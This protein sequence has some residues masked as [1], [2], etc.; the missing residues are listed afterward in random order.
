MSSIW[1]TGNKGMLGAELSLLLEKT[2]VAFIGSDREVDITD[3]ATLNNFVQGRGIKWIINCAAYTA[4]DK[5]EDEQ[6]A[7]RSL[8]TLGAA[9]IAVFAKSINARLIHISTD[10]VFDGNGIKEENNTRPYREDDKTNP[11]GIYGLTKRDGETVILENNPGSY[12]IRTAWLYGKH[13]NNFVHTMLRLMNERDEIKVVNDQR[14][15][16]TWTFDLASVILTIINSTDSGKNIPFGIYHF[17]NEGNITWF[18][19]ANEIYL[20]GRKLGCIQK[21]CSVLSCTSA[22]YQTKVKRPEYS[23]LDKNKIKT[24]LG[25]EIPAWDTSLRSF[26]KH[27]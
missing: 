11:I 14:G 7:S 13:G 15:S 5:A 18:D 24:A 9:N 23:V 26:L 27:A 10:Y 22:E 25:I 19:F 1:I 8:N 17:S 16:P 3:L 21:N 2:G 12:I 6:E 4:V 20:Q